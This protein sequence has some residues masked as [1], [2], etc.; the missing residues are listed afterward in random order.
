MAIGPEINKYML[1]DMGKRAFTESRVA[2]DKFMAI[3]AY[4]AFHPRIGSEPDPLTTELGYSEEDA[5][6][7][8]DVFES[9]GEAFEALAPKFQEA[10][11]I[12]GLE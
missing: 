3:H 2:F 7:F 4:L 8:R 12:T 6:T 10:R 9:F 5:Y 1:D 11:K